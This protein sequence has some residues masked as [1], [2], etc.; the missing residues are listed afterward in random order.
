MD[1]TGL[2]TYF[3]GTNGVVGLFDLV[4]WWS[5]GVWAVSF[6][7]VEGGGG[8]A[9]FVLHRHVG[10]WQALWLISKSDRWLP[11]S[12]VKY[13]VFLNV[14]LFFYT[15]KHSHL[16]EPCSMMLSSLSPTCV[17]THSIT[18]PLTLKGFSDGLKSRRCVTPV[19]HEW[20]SG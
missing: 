11:V 8:G 16:L 5:C 9:V 13:F 3:K 6:F 4:W 20:L 19:W 1:W 17:F 10:R 14:F 15:E 12:T 18:A 2:L 7:F